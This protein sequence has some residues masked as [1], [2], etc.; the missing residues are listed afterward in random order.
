MIKKT[1]CVLFVLWP[2]CLYAQ[3]DTFVVAIMPFKAID[4]PDSH[5]EVVTGLFETELKKTG[6]FQ[7][8]EQ[9]RIEEILQT[10]Q[11]S[12]SGLT[13]ENYA[14]ELGKLASA[15]QII[16][17]DL[18]KL[19]IKFYLNVKLLDV[20]NGENLT[21]EWISGDSIDDLLGEKLNELIDGLVNL[22]KQQRELRAISLDAN[23]VYTRA[24]LIQMIEALQIEEKDKILLNKKRT[25]AGWSM[26]GL[27]FGAAAFSGISYGISVSQHNAQG[28]AILAGN[29]DQLSDLKSNEDGWLQS[30]WI[31]GGIGVGGLI[32]SIALLAKTD[33]AIGK[34]YM[35]KVEHLKVLMENLEKEKENEK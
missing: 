24:E 2:L 27:S 10:H 11:Y 33:K 26:L 34:E 30:C 19:G 6:M 28:D 25:K 35:V 22:L 12:L 4:V 1:L 14:V 7:I 32:T 23:P 8:I 9:N 13:D 21:A 15:Q 5:A 29:F 3:V 18:S 16:V 31:S 20:E 17:G